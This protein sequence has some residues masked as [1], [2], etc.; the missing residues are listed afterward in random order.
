M[1]QVKRLARAGGVILLTLTSGNAFAGDLIYRPIVPGL[2]GNPD[3]WTPLLGAAQIDNRFAPQSSG[4]GGGAPEINFP[5]ITI[6]LGGI[7]GTPPTVPT[8]ATPTASA[9]PAPS[10]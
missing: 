6:D 8:P 3:Y 2:G 4:G 5:P 1:N 10:N 9:A 7:G